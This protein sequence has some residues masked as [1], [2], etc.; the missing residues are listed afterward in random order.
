MKTM[1]QAI[2]AEYAELRAGRAGAE[3]PEA[4]RQAFALVNM[5]QL[6]ADV[7]LDIFYSLGVIFTSYALVAQPGMPRLVGAYGLLV[8]SGLLVLNIWTFPTPPR[9]AGAVDLGPAST[10][11]WIGVFLL[12][13]RLDGLAARKQT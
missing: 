11:W 2:F 3:V 10:V 8:G 12:V 9:E 13:R 5:V 1:Q 6:G 4:L 7:A